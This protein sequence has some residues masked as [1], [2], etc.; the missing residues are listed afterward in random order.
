MTYKETDPH[1]YRV[2]IKG[3]VIKDKKVLLTQEGR[4]IGGHWTML[5]GGLE[6]SE[7]DH[8]TC[9]KREIAEETGLVVTKVAPH[10]LFIIRSYM[11]SVETY[12]LDVVYEIELE[13]LDFTPS[14][15]CT[16]LKFFSLEEMQDLPMFSNG[17]ELRRLLKD[18]I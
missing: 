6:H 2:S 10:P 11:P 8:E 16:D 12:K 13:N 18:I 14:E 7:I 4:E 17:E 15:E 5:G 9:L 1:I 3:I